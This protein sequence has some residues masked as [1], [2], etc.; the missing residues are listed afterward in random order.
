M[1]PATDLHTLASPST[2]W[3]RPLGAEHPAGPDLSLTEVAALARAA[4]LA[5]PP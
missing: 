3:T 2:P 5:P 4:R 1:Q